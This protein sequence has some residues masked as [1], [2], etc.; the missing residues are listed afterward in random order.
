MFFG[1]LFFGF[2]IF[3]FFFLNFFSTFWTVPRD[4]DGNSYSRHINL[5][6]TYSFQ[7]ATHNS[8]H[9]NN[10]NNH[11]PNNNNNTNKTHGESNTPAPFSSTMEINLFAPMVNRFVSESSLDDLSQ[12][13]SIHCMQAEVWNYWLSIITIITDKKKNDNFHIWV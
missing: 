6:L 13:S 10:N 7:N 12:D 4:S 1:D 3:F 2:D 5:Q 8:L 11:I 9:M